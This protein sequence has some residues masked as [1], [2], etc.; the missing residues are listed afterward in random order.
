MDRDDHLRRNREGAARRRQAEPWR[1]WYGSARWKRVRKL[2][3]D[4]HPLCKRCEA[5]GKL[6]IASVVHHAKPHKGDAVLFWD[7]Q[8]FVSSCAPCHNIDEQRV[9]RGGMAR[10]VVGPDGWPIDDV[11]REKNKK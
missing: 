10:Q 9:E 5:R 7:A 2:H 4:Q 1:R 8:N 11:D 3:L 6:T